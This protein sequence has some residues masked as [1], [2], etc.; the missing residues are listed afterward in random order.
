MKGDRHK[1]RAEAIA[2]ILLASAGA[3]SAPAT[4]P[5]AAG[6]APLKSAVELEFPWKLTAGEYWYSTYRGTDVNLR[7]RRSDTSAW[8]GIYRDPALGTQVRTGADTSV[9]IAKSVQ[10]QPSIQLA[11]HGF[12]GGS[13]TLQMGNAWYGILGIGRTNAKPYFN[14]N[15]DPNDAITVG[16]GRRLDDGTTYNLFLVADDRLHTRQRDWHLN[17]KIPLRNSRATFDILRKSGISDVGYI[18]GW[19]FSANWDRPR[20][21]LRAVYDPYQNFSAQNVWRLASGIRF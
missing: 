13:L 8:L 7:W 4:G 11:S 6:T 9:D 5:A 17:I 19:G 21:F 20:W 15:F 18:T 10:L 16:A 1:R 12:V 3:L 14:L 2:L